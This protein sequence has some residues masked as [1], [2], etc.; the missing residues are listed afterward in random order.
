MKLKEIN[1]IF[2]SL[3]KLLIREDLPIKLSYPL[4]KLGKLIENESRSFEESRMKIIEK[5]GEKDED[6]KLIQKDNVINIPKDN[7]DDFNLEFNELLDINMTFSFQP[8][9][10]ASLD[11]NL[12]ISSID[13]MILSEFFID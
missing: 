12:N 7:L 3:N 13:L 1:N 9:S 4:S 8:I 5:H 10:I 2:Q 11:E 6:G